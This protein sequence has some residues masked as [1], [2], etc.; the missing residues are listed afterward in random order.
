MG[1]TS[2]LFL[3]LIKENID[4]FGETEHKKELQDNLINLDVNLTETN[5]GNVFH[6][7]AKIFENKFA[8]SIDEY[9]G[10]NILV[11]L[12]NII[13]ELNLDSYDLDVK[14]EAFEYFI[15]YGNIKSD[16]GE[17]FTPRHIVK[18]MTK[19][20]NEVMKDRW[21]TNNKGEPLTYFDPTCGTGGFL[22]NIFKELRRETG[23]D[24]TLLDRIK[25][26]YVYGTE[27]SK[28]TSEIAKMNMILA[29]D[30]H[31][32]IVNDDF[33]RYKSSHKNIYD[34]SIGNMPFGKKI[35]EPSFVE[36]FL[37]VVK[38]G[39]Y[40]I[41]I[42]PSGIIGTISK[43]EYIRIR[44]KLLTQ[45]KLLKLIS[46]PQGV[47]APYTFSKTYIIFWKKEKQITD[48]DIEYF[49]I[50]TDGFTLNNQ[51]DIIKG[52][53]DLDLYYKDKNALIKEKKLFSVNS[54]KLFNLK[55]FNEKIVLLNSLSEKKEQNE[56][57]IRIL[58]KQ[59]KDI[60]DN[61]Q[62]EEKQNRK[63]EIASDILKIYE[64][65]KII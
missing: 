37:D 51:R 4:L 41:F 32:N 10:N 30:G 45:G 62:L 54:S 42:V 58:N 26:K 49:E 47:F 23:D 2:I 20:L 65:I 38:E 64:Q 8:F 63:A 25:T 12:W 40:S 27:L 11:E 61:K 18:F 55:E 14:G 36:G 44:E 1:T 5:I 34:V 21:L 39:G 24:P 53:S 31:T 22:I 33:L 60:T 52:D 16:M 29:G 50:Q 15:N 17:Y 35:N 28:R 48:Y 59:I 46:L 13:K 56:D 57:K 7:I 43:K 6:T 3:K 19:C 9:L